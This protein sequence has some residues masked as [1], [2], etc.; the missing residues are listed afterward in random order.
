M[1]ASNSRPEEGMSLQLCHDRKKIVKKA[2]GC[3]YVLAEAH[4]TYIQ[5]LKETGRDLLEF[6]EPQVPKKSDLRDST[7]T[8]KEPL[9]PYQPHSNEGSPRKTEERVSS[10]VDESVTVPIEKQEDS[11]STP[12]PWDF[13][14]LS[15]SVDDQL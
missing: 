9:V 10:P 11:V 5:T 15:H 3:R 13:F 14:A 12:S 7:D 8:N 4:L 1:G 2:I 6:F